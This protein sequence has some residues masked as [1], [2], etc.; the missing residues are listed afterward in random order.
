MNEDGRTTTP[1][2]SDWGEVDVRDLDAQW[3]LETFL[4]KSLAE[5]EALFAKNALYYSEAL[6]SMPRVPF[7]FY[8]RA[9]ARYLTSGGAR[10]DSD[11]ASSFLRLLAWILEKH[12]EIVEPETKVILLRAAEHVA[13]DQSFYEANV[14]IYGR[15]AERFN[16]IK[17]LSRRPPRH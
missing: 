3:A 4:G 17:R 13:A 7:N 8:A 1:T 16:R 14:S 9:L 6:E 11:G 2:R 5:A 10:G 15:F 12:P